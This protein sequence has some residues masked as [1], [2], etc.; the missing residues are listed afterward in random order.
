MA[1]KCPQCG[2]STLESVVVPDLQTRF[3][4][5]L[6]KVPDAKISRCSN[7]GKESYSARELKRWREIKNDLLESLHQLPT[8]GDIKRIRGGFDLSVSE[9]ADLICV[10]RQTVHLWERN[11]DA[12]MKFGPAAILIHLLDTELKGDIDQV[13]AQLL[14]FAQQRGQLEDVVERR[15]KSEGPSGPVKQSRLVEAPNGAPAWSAV[16]CEA[17]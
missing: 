1:R 3:E 7:C 13:F 5:V 11:E 2:E 16:V 10:T 4:G 8:G 9:F 12:Q 6:I 15:T 17:A 14:S